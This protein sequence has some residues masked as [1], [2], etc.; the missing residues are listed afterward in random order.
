MY[1]S[2]DFKLHSMMRAIL[3]G[4]PSHLSHHAK[5]LKLQLLILS[6]TVKLVLLM[7][8]QRFLFFYLLFFVPSVW[9]FW[10]C[11]TLLQLQIRYL[12][13]RS[14]SNDEV[15]LFEYKLLG[16]VRMLGAL[17][18]HRSI[19]DIYGHQLSSKWVQVEGDKE[20]RILQS[21]I[22]MEYVNGGSLKVKIIYHVYDFLL[23]CFNINSDVHF[24][25]RT[26]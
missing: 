11:L 26:C 14:A 13:T 24:W 25:Y 12:D 20:Y 8:L 23:Y 1:H 5:K 22:L 2:V 15:K 19:V 7:L 9:Y 10:V 3:L 16:E 6:I 4:V 18:K 17:R 21:I